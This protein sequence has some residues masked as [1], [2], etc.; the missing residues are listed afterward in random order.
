MDVNSS[1]NNFATREVG[2]TL[3]I[4]CND[5]LSPN[6]CWEATILL[7]RILP[8]QELWGKIKK[9]FYSSN[10][11]FKNI[12]GPLVRSCAYHLVFSVLKDSVIVQLYV[13]KSVEACPRVKASKSPF[14]RFCHHVVVGLWQW[15][16]HLSVLSGLVILIKSP[17]RLSRSITTRAFW[18]VLLPQKS[19][20]IHWL[21]NP[22]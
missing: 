3:L 8:P 10:S 11:G 4:F 2:S 16:R 7:V 20:K 21:W 14:K 6:I 15:R 22:R 17:P 5:H 9:L 19:C 12:G 18:T 13:A 1:N